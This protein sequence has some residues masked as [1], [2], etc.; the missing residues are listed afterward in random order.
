MSARLPSHETI[1]LKYAPELFTQWHWVEV[2][3]EL[4]SHKELCQPL[5][6]FPASIDVH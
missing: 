2:G 6:G 4:S 5:G 1:A 3:F